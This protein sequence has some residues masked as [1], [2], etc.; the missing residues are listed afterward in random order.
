MN[1][2]LF[3]IKSNSGFS[4][5]EV[6]MACFAGLLV[7]LMAGSAVQSAFYNFYS[8]EMKLQVEESVNYASMVL[9]NYI[10]MAVNLQVAAPPLT[11]FDNNVGQIR[12]YNLNT[13]TATTGPGSIDTIAYFLREN[14]PS[15]DHASAITGAQ[16]F[17]VTA[18]FFQR[19]TVDKYG[20]LYIQTAGDYTTPLTPKLS[21]FRIPGIVDFE[22]VDVVSN[23]F[24]NFGNY[25]SDVDLEG[26]QVVAGVLIKIT[27][28]NYFGN[29]LEN[30]TWC[31]QR[32]IATN[33]TCQSPTPYK[34]TEKTFLVNIRNNILSRGISQRELNPLS[35]TQ[36][37][38]L[39]RRSADTVYFF[40]PYIPVGVTR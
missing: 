20:V 39:Y 5:T 40:K 6:L 9:R 14:L 32:F 26:R 12:E 17:P 35:T 7:V 27:M 29:S 23:E 33:P 8:L 37:S 19:P 16:R 1:K 24:V 21:D 31:P 28:R 36:T 18:F 15:G 34:D 30:L 22:I 13:W 10:S 2:F 3:R 4:L 25:V 11:N 38:P